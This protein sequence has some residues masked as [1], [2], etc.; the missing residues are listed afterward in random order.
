MLQRSFKSCL[1]ATAALLF[2][3]CY[4]LTDDNFETQ[5][6][7]PHFPGSEWQKVADPETL[8]WSADKLDNVRDYAE[9]IKTE[10]LMIVDD[11]R[12]VAAF[13]DTDRKYYVASVRKSY[14]ST[15]FGFYTDSLISLD[16]T[17]ADYGIDDKNPSLNAA[18]KAAKVRHLLTSSSGVY[19]K[20]AANDNND[21]LP[22]RNSTDP[23]EVFYYNNWDFN[24][25]GTIFSQRTGKDIYEDFD[26]RIAVPLQMQDFVWQEDGRLDYS[27]VSEHPAY[28]FDM[29]AR[30]MARFGVLLQNQGNWD[31]QQ[32]LP[33][34]WVQESTS[35]Q[36]AVGNDYG[37]G[38]YGFMWWLHDSGE[39]ASAGFLPSAFSAQ[40][41]WSQLILVDPEKKLVIVHRAYNRKIDGE[42]IKTL[43]EKILEAK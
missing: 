42:K 21:E 24:A 1:F 35:P 19:H 33:L 20:S 30:D 22:P 3:G 40:G 28:H 11:G 34:A 7:P 41:N 4:D 23:G 5:A 26:E 43:L 6:M 8:D 32:I 31:G 38:S 14:L 12:L 13:G 2:S 39:I 25:L 16:A 29:T 37:G 15:L 18:E 9:E 36:I 27:S 17:L 10:A